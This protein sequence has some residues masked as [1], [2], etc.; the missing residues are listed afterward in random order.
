MRAVKKR[1][2]GRGGEIAREGRVKTNEHNALRSTSSYLACFVILKRTRTYYIRSHSLKSTEMRFYP[3]GLAHIFSFFFVSLQLLIIIINMDDIR[4]QSASTQRFRH[5]PLNFDRACTVL[6]DSIFSSWYAK[7]AK[8]S[9][10]LNAL[11]SLFLLLYRRVRV[12]LLIISFCARAVYN[13]M[14]LTEW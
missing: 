9:A 4:C 8:I 14:C 12:L 11:C 1:R 3:D 7:K 10:S 13:S 2:R 5:R 6:K